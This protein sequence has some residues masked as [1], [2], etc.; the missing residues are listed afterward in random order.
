MALCKLC[1]QDRQLIRSHILPDS[2]NR[3]LRGDAATPP[4]M[5]SNNPEKHPK[6][7]PGGHYDEEL[8]CLEC[9]ERFGLADDYAAKFFL[10]RFRTDGQTLAVEANG[11]AMAFQYQDVDYNLLKMFA[12]SLLWRASATSIQFFERVTTGP[13]EERLRQMI[14]ANDPGVADEFSTFVTRWVSRP[15]HEAMA[16]TQ[17]SPYRARLDGINEVK[18]LFAGAVMHVKVDKRPYPEPFPAF[19]IRPGSPLIVVA[20]ELEGSKD[21]Q[22]VRPGLEAVAARVQQRRNRIR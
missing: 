21:I 14:L 6:R 4:L 3:D 19:I 17:L 22:A 16:Q 9:E 12:I 10:G 8:V 5:I 20:R 15:E 1:L 2:F 7:L 13:H 11:D 18:F